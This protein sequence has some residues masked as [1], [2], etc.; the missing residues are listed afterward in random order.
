VRASR[1]LTKVQLLFLLLL[2]LLLLLASIL[3]SSTSVPAPRRTS[4]C[5]L[6]AL[7]A[8]PGPEQRECQNIYI[9]TYLYYVNIFVPYILPNGMPETMFFVMNLIC[10]RTLKVQQSRDQH[11]SGVDIIHP[12][13]PW[14]CLARPS[15]IPQLKVGLQ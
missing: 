10:S 6:R 4:H 7:W 14:V 1:F 5:E 13:W 12:T 15:S 8:G 3:F 9:Y 11:A 2:F